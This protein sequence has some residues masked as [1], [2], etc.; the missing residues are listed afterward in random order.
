L[1]QKPQDLPFHAITAGPQPPNAAELLRGDGLQRLITE[2]SRSFDHIIVDSP[3]VMGLADAPLIVNT[4]EGAV[5][6]VEAHGK[7]ARL[8]RQAIGR[9]RKG[10]ARLLGVILCKFD[11][12]Q[13]SYGY[14]HE[15]GYGYGHRYGEAARPAA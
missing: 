5:F 9:L 7:K 15:Y 2:L 4:T 14:G 8:V 11:A 6:I 3:P 13:G 1:L 12:R 10:R